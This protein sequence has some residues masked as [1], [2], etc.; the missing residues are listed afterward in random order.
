[1]RVMH[2]AH[3]QPEDLVL[4]LHHQQIE[5]PAVSLLYTLDELLVLL[6]G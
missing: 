5:S 1:M 3:D 6:L 4:I 2:E